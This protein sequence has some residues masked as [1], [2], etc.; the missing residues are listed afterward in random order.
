MKREQLILT[1][2]AAQNG[3][4]TA[5]NDLFNAYYQN[6]YYFALK[7]VKDQDIAFE[8]IQEAFVEIISTLGKLQEPA[9]FVTWA[10]QIIYHQ[11]SHYFKKK[12]DILVDEGDDGHSVFDNIEED[13]TEFIPDAALDQEDFRKTILSMLDQ[14][15]DEQRAATMM[16]YF[17]ELSVKQIAQIQG[18]SEGTVKSRL[19]YARKAI[20][21]SVESYEK[22]TGIKL[23]SFGLVP[24]FLWLFR[25]A[26]TKNVPARAVKTTASAVSAATGTTIS[27]AT[28]TSVVTT[29]FAAKIA[30]A[31]VAA[32]LVVGGGVAVTK[33][34]PPSSPSAIEEPAAPENNYDKEWAA[35]KVVFCLPGAIQTDTGSENSAGEQLQDIPTDMEQSF[36]SIDHDSLND[37]YEQMG[38]N[39]NLEDFEKVLGAVISQGG[40]APTFPGNSQTAA[41]N[42]MN[43]PFHLTTRYTDKTWQLYSMSSGPVI[44]NNVTEQTLSASSPEKAK[45]IK[46]AMTHKSDPEQIAYNMVFNDDVNIFPVE[47]I[48]KLPADHAY[49]FL[50]VYGKYYGGEISDVNF[51]GITLAEFNEISDYVLGKTYRASEFTGLY[52][53]YH[54]NGDYLEETASDKNNTIIMLPTLYTVEFSAFRTGSDTKPAGEEGTDYIYLEESEKYLLY[55]YTSV[56]IA[57]L[58]DGRM[59]F[60]S[61]QK[62]E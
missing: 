29:S 19:N 42:L 9:A 53:R 44:M 58:V 17:D 31:V 1:V 52:A 50:S 2:S 34:T 62:P 3:D 20:R 30:A 18:V 36:P 8:V 39:G 25:D 46:K 38:Q 51:D 33:L 15:S 37:L 35:W 41:T 6:F 5:L 40:R 16:Y 26:F 21:A 7:I 4:S 56:V 13:R 11:C 59:Q 60:Y 61:F 14:L 43:M 54:T 27:V 45:N 22:K 10:K 47:S 49:H 48:D 28:A 57:K 32:S 12:N 24:L 23:H 55:D